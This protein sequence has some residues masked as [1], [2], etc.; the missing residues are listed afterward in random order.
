MRSSTIVKA[1]YTGQNRFELCHVLFKA[2]RTLHRP[3][4]RIQDTTNDIL[5][6]LAGAER[7]EVEQPGNVNEARPMEVKHEQFA[8]ETRAEA[9][10]ARAEGVPRTMLAS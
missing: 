7:L 5:R 9:L 8:T 1:L 2:I 10:R 4:D 3:G 6:C